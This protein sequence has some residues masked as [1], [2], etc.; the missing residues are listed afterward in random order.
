MSAV[1]RAVA[2]VDL[3]AIERNCA[4]L[5]RPLC[6]VVKADGYG[7]GAVA[8]AALSGGASWLAVA[9]AGEA[10]ALRDQGVEAPILVMGAVTPAELRVAI[11]AGAD[12]VAWTEQVAEVAPRVHVKFDTGLGRLGTRTASWRCG[13]PPGRTWWG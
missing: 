13:W 8:A 4:R 10:R 5:P 1:E 9:A 2:T 12:V 6:A 3:G 11:D 7:H